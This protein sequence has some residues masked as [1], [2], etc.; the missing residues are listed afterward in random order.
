MPPILRW[1]WKK[2][3]TEHS[4]EPRV[5]KQHMSFSHLLLYFVW[6]PK[7]QSYDSFPLGL[8][9]RWNS[10]P[11]ARDPK[12]YQLWVSPAKK[13]VALKD[14]GSSNTPRQLATGWPPPTFP[15]LFSLNP[16]AM[17]GNNIES[18][19][20]NRANLNVKGMLESL[21]EKGR[22][23]EKLLKTGLQDQS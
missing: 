15:T 16:S 11:I 17:G 2:Q 3:V 1:H 5:R 6:F 13:K 18:L 8:P 10:L 12:Q 19:F 20:L 9:S 14:S 7:I 23:I 4:G 22:N 21:D